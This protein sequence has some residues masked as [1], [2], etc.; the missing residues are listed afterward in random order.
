MA[1]YI[2]SKPTTFRNRPVGVVNV[3]TGA[4]QAANIVRTE[5]SNLLPNIF[6]KKKK[7]KQN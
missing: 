2:K 6:K 1:Q 5:A 7:Y 3:N 4:I